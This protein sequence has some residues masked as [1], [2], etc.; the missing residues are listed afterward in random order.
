MLFDDLTQKT[1]DDL[2]FTLRSRWEGHIYISIR[3]IL[4][5]FLQLNELTTTVRQLELDIPN[6]E[7]NIVQGVLDVIRKRKSRTLL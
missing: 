7:R 1:F 6:M 4:T 2:P 5:F 3:V